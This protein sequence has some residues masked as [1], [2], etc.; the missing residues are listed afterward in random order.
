MRLLVHTGDYIGN[1]ISERR[2]FS[3]H[4]KGYNVP[5][6]EELIKMVS[7]LDFTNLKSKDD[8]YYQH[9]EERKL[10]LEEFN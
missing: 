7:N 10:M 1:I 3:T 9:F 5:S 8:Q 4:K 2:G 6:M